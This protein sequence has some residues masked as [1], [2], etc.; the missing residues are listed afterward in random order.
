MGF[1][2]IIVNADRSERPA[3]MNLPTRGWD[4]FCNWAK[5]AMREQPPWLALPLLVDDGQVLGDDTVPTLTAEIDLA[6]SILP[7][8][9][10]VRATADAFLEVLK[11]AERD[12]GLVITD[13]VS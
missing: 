8:P 7:P 9:A 5:R 2:V 10:D 3:A 12:G 13:G 1:E 6:L 11:H 4:R